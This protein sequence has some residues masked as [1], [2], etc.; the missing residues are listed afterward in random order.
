MVDKN[1]RTNPEVWPTK[2]LVE[3]IHKDISDLKLAF[4]IVLKPFKS[5]LRQARDN[6]DS[7]RGEKDRLHD[8]LAAVMQFI[9]KRHPE[10][11][12]EALALMLDPSRKGWRKFRKSWRHR[13]GLDEP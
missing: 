4:D 1:A 2:K 9:A 10:S 7:L 6:V 8:D 11:F 13:V 12:D 3:F 5:E